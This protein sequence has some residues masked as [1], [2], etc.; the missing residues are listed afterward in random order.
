MKS[1]KEKEE[2][3]DNE[4]AELEAEIDKEELKNEE[5]ILNKP[6][7][8]P[9]DIEEKYHNIEK[10]VSLGVLE[11]EKLYC[12]RIIKYKK[13]I[14]KDFIFWETKKKQITKKVKSITALIEKKTMN[15]NT[16]KQKIKEE[17]DNDDNLLLLVDKEPNLNEEQKEILKERINERKNII[18]EELNQNVEEEE[19]EINENLDDLIINETMNI[20]LYPETVEDIYHNQGKFV[21]LG[22][23]EK[24]KELCDKIIKYKMEK[25]MGFNTWETKK[26]NIDKNISSITSLVE[27][28]TWN[29]DTYKQKI[30]EQKNW[31]KNL[32]NLSKNDTSLNETQK[33][34]I[35]IRIKERINAIDAELKQNPEED[36]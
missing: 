36:D 11:K 32:L 35:K 20:D 4:L 5:E 15:F 24:E 21:C 17:K 8:Y 16:Y 9:Y 31:E 6:D 29:L 7:L 23:L 2:N 25:N 12:F 19:E 27:N 14:K 34:V 30:Q 26:E 22:V 33:K 10:M 13:K 1:T 18:E 28:G 3:I